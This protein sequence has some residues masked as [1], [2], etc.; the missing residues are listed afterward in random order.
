MRFKRRIKR[1]TKQY[2]IVALICITFIG[3]AATLTSYT[4]YSQVKAEYQT[5]LNKANH[6]MEVNQKDAYTAVTDIPSGEVIKEEMLVKKKVYSSQPQ[7]TYISSKDIGKI[8]VVN[9]PAGTQIQNSMITEYN[10]SNK[11]REMEYQVINM[12]SNISKHDTVDIR[13][14]YPNGESYVVLTK[15]EIMAYTAETVS[16]YLWMDEE[17]LLRMSAAIVDAALYP[18]SK[19]FV[20]KYIEPNIQEASM[21]NY[22]PGLSILSLIENDPNIID[23]CSQKLNKDIRKALENR[24]ADSMASD[25]ST[26]NWNVDTN[27]KFITGSTVEKDDANSDTYQHTEDD[28]TEKEKDTGNLT[29]T[30]SPNNKTYTDFESGVSELGSESYF[31]YVDEGIKKS[32]NN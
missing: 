22:T 10:I 12:N 24:L 13:I 9:I 31:Y 23:R 19:L 11:M 3:G 18:G 29:P 6:E 27:N 5:L 4:I 2:I 20:T 32:E 21:V 1:S 14:C 25:V 7:E 8:A 15:K 28:N 16:V 17:E 30:L 26:A